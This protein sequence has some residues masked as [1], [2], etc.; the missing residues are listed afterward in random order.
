MSEVF[1]LREEVLVRIEEPEG[2]IIFYPAKD[3]LMILNW[4]GAIYVKLLLHG[5]TCK[6]LISEIQQHCEVKDEDE[7][8]KDIQDF[9]AKL[10]KNQFI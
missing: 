4:M 3:K 1:R 7:V 10:I 2:A 6:D 5:A 9:I 8:E